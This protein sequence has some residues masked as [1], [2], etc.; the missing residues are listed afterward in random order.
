MKRCIVGIRRPDAPEA[1]GRRQYVPT[2][3]FPSMA[4]MAAVLSE[5]NRAL[6]RI[7]HDRKPKSLTELAELTG[8]QV[9]NLSRTLRMMEGYGLVTIEKNAR[10][11]QPIAL[12][13]E[14]LV[15]LD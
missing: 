11:T 2:V 15:V 7:V 1:P 4:T 9:P 13:T 14:F 8:R 12:A 3:W 10:E 5:D 6:L